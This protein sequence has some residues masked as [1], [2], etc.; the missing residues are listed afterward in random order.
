MVDRLFDIASKKGISIE[1]FK[2]RIKNSSI[3]MFQNKLE[4]Y[5]TS[6]VN[7]YNIK[8]KSIIK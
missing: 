1:L 6:D 5:E 4:N 2:T 8:A 7:S 3:K